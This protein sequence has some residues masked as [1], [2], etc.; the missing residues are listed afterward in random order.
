MARRP[1]ASL[2]TLL[3]PRAAALTAALP[4]ALAGEPEAVHEAR[5]ASRRLREVLPALTV[6]QGRAGRALRKDVRRVT[7][8]FSAVRELDVALG[9]FDEA[10]TRAAMSAAVR[11]STRRVLQAQRSAALRQAQATLT[12]AR[13]QR[14]Q[15]RLDE[16]RVAATSASA[17]WSSSSSST[18]AAVMA[19][20][21]ARVE[22]RALGLR[23]AVV[24][25]G[26][27]YMPERLHAVR[28]A[29]KR[30]RYALEAGQEARG[31]R[32]TAQLTQ[33]KAIQSLLGRAHDLHVLAE[34]LHDVELSVV[35]QSRATARALAALAGALDRECR[36]LHAAFMSR[37]NGLLTLSAV[38][39]RA[40]AP[41]VRSVA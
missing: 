27:V 4:A 3:A 36:V 14:L 18:A 23:K 10:V 35:Q 22:G 20:M 40:S 39:T 25:T 12:R 9:H 16:L 11:A 24:A 30:L 32:A 21:A 33:L 2:T 17:S 7:R 19:A 34:R 38:L 26:V 13:L 29:V 41:R 8:A 15:A 6:T 5:V 37:R 28:I 31:V 1:P